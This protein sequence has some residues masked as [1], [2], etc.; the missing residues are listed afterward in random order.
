M[1][2]NPSDPGTGSSPV[3]SGESD[4]SGGRFEIQYQLRERGVAVVQLGGR[5]DGKAVHALGQTIKDMFRQ[6]RFRLIFDCAAM[7]YIT[8]GGIG[9]IA[10]ALTEAQANG[11]DIVL[12]QPSPN[13]KQV[14]KLL[15]LSELIPVAESIKDALGSFNWWPHEK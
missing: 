7:T 6:D 5:M 12:I 15:G 14:I 3:R 9:A 11:G 8:S 13:V 4:N 10:N 2:T 1:N